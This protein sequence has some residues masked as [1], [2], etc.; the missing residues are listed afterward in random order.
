MTQT[1]I[2]GGYTDRDD[3][4][5]G[6][7]SG[8]GL[9]Q[10]RDDVASLVATVPVDNPTWF[11]WDAR[12]RVLYVSQSSL[13][14]LTAVAIPGDARSARVLDVIELGAVNPAHLALA[15]TGDAVVA[16]CFTE[17][18]VVTVA[19][20]EDGSF[21]GVRG[22]V[23]LATER[24]AEP[25]QISFGGSGFAVP[26]RARDEI[27]RFSWAA[28]SAPELRGSDPQPAGRGPRHLARHPRRE[29]IA[30]LAGELDSTVTALRTGAEGFEAAGSASTLP[31]GYEGENSVAAVFVDAA[32]TLYVSNRGHDSLASFD[33]SDP[34]APR[35]TGHLDAGG[36]TPRFAGE[37]APGL[38]AS[39]AMDSHSVDLIRD[40]RSRISIAHGAPACVRL[41][42]L[43]AREA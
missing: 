21:D 37:I 10:W 8:L 30:Y 24:N 34:L 42:D 12:R 14:T 7:A 22:R 13:T 23:D 2:I 27:H 39:A 17:G 19:L 38:I 29:D 25:H 32:G 1:L 20:A 41:I 40:G 33:I 15:P 5:V 11:E 35:P 4:P 43:D 18:Q 36:R 9:Y 31:T 3:L 26:D 16:A 28:G 6:A